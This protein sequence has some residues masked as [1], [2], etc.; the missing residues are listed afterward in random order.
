MGHGPGRGWRTC[1]CIEQVHTG[2]GRLSVGMVCVVGLCDALIASFD[3][4]P[5]Y[6]RHTKRE[7]RRPQGELW[8][9]FPHEASDHVR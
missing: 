6:K 4:I 9:D 3:G 5:R 1:G 2:I 7:D 8:M